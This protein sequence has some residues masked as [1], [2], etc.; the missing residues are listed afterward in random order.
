ME[1]KGEV[2]GIIYQNDMNSYTVAEF[3]TDESETVI[4][5]YLPFI[6]IG[7][8]LKLQGSIV[9]H[10]DYGEQFKVTTFEKLMP[11]TLG[12]LE[13]YLSNGTIKGV[14]PATA[15]RIIKEFGEETIHVLKFEPRRLANIKGI[16]VDKAIQISETFIENWELWQIVGFLEKFN[17][18]VQ[19]AKNVYKALGAN[20]IEEIEANPYILV[21]VANNVDFKKIDKMAIDLGLPYNYEKRVKSGIKYALICASYNGHCCVLL[22][23]LIEFCKNLLGIEENDVEDNIIELKI[24]G[25]IKEE[26]RI[27]DETTKK[28]I[29]L[30]VFYNAEEN[31]ADKIKIL[32]NSKNI[33]RI[34]DIEKELKLIENNSE[35]ELS[36]KQK[37]AIESVNEN[38]V[39]IITGGPGTGKTTIIKSII[40]IYKKYGK[41]VVLCAPTGRAAK[42][43]TQTTKEEAK[44]LH[45]LLEIG[46]FESEQGTFNNKEYDIAPLDADVV[47]V[48][49]MSMV[50]IFLMNYLSKALYQGTKLVLVGDIDQLPS[51]GPGCVLKDLIN[52]EEITTIVL[53]KIFRQAAKSKIIVNA[54]RVNEGEMFLTSKAIEE[55]SNITSSDI[56]NVD[57]IENTNISNIDK[58]ELKEDFFYIKE[59][60]QEKILYNIISLCKDR[61]K[62]YGNYNFFK[63]IQVLTP[64]KK[65]KLGTKELNKILQENLNPPRDYLKQKSFGEVIYRENDRVMQIKN[66]Y[67]I[68]WE[69]QANPI[70]INSKYESGTGIFN[71][72]LGV[73][74]KI[75]EMEKTITIKFDDEKV[76]HY[77]FSEIE[78]IEHAY[79]ITIH[80][81]Q[82][83]EFDVAIM[84]VP[85]TAPQLLTRN[86]LYTGMTR[87]K[88]MLIII[89]NPNLVQYMIQNA[90]NKKRNTGLK[91]K[92]NKVNRENE[93]Y[94]I[95]F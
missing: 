13:R 16:T 70:E 21:D 29:Y 69:K 20:A 25:E 9:T 77:Q 91:Y 63:N 93:S 90:D 57:T 39:C 4:V 26:E 15:K 71:G 74:E 28:W 33:K 56:N 1:I 14:G 61:L 62:N 75:D 60:N 17:I 55:D 36:N 86:L 53:N 5:G 49:E 73:I 38:N 94:N 68:F 44:T 64:T 80:K 58:R 46:K 32:N 45:R 82:G 52:S 92:M 54:H 85:Q 24:K 72:E 81:A 30:S 18:G 31:V 78:Q 27:E 88:E 23:N 76:A 79:A 12:A 37:E 66:N 87:A 84:V 51:V 59:I 6:N 67:D 65:G 19:N 3:E 35:I 41:K 95:I 22:E 34:S 7:D 89:G 83:S 42:R 10:Q 8:T 43:M 2:K 48:D 40:E 11:E 50:D 47:I